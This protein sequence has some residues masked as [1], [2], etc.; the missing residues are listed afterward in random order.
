MGIYGV[1][2]RSYRALLDSTKEAAIR[3]MMGVLIFLGYILLSLFMYAIMRR[4][5]VPQKLHVKPVHL[6]FK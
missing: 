2:V 6:Y 5:M 4:V 1:L 3:T